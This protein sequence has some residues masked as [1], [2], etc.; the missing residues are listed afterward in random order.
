METLQYKIIKT[1]AQYN[2]YCETLEALVDSRKKTKAVQ[3]EI[4]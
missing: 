2:R 4:E 3:D 1:G